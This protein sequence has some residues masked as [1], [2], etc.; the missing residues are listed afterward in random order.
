M[1]KVKFDAQVANL[2]AEDY[3]YIINSTED[4]IQKSSRNSLQTPYVPS[5]IRGYDVD[6]SSLDLTQVR[7]YHEDGYG[8]AINYYGT[9]IESTDETDQISLSDYTNG[10]VNYIYLKY[11]QTDASYNRQTG[12]IEDGVK[13]AVDLADFSHEYDRAVDTQ[14]FV[15]YTLSEYLATSTGEQR[16]LI[17]L[18]TVVAQGAGNPLTSVSTFGRV[19]GKTFITENTIS[20]QN[21]IGGFSLPQIQV[22]NS[23]IYNDYYTSTGTATLEDDLNRL[24]T[25]IRLMKGTLD[26]EDSVD[27]NL[28]SFDYGV[29]RLHFN[30]LLEYADNLS[31]VVTSSGTV[32]QINRGKALV[33]GRVLWVEYEPLYLDV[34]DA[35]RRNVGNFTERTGGELHAVGVQPA[36]FYLTHSRIGNLYVT[37]NANP[38]KVYVQDIDYT[39][40]SVTGLVTTIVGG[41]IVSE[42]LSC[43]YEWGYERYDSIEVTSTGQVLYRTGEANDY[44]SPPFYSKDYYR[45][46]TIYRPQL[47]ATITDDNILDNRTNVSYVREVREIPASQ[48][49]FQKW[50][51]NRFTYCSSDILESVEDVWTEWQPNINGSEYFTTT[52]NGAKVLTTIYTNE[53]DELW[54]RVK[55]GP[56]EGTVKVYIEEVPGTQIFNEEITI[57]PYNKLLES[58]EVLVPVKKG[59]TRGYHNVKIELISNDSFTI[60]SMLIGKLES[61]YYSTAANM[62]DLFA[63]NLYAVDLYAE[64]FTTSILVADAAVL[65]WKTSTGYRPYVIVEYEGDLYKCLDEHVSTSTGTL[66]DDA[67]HWEE[68]GTSKRKAENLESQITTLQSTI[69]DQRSLNLQ[70]EIRLNYL[71]HKQFVTSSIFSEMFINPDYTENVTASYQKIAELMDDIDWNNSYKQVDENPI[72]RDGMLRPRKIPYMLEIVDEYNLDGVGQTYKGAISRYDTTN[73]C[74][75]FITAKQTNDIGE[76]VKLSTQMEDGKVEVLGRWYLSAGGTSTWWVGIEVDVSNQYLH[77][78][79]NADGTAGGMA[80][81]KINDD[82]TLG[83]KHKSNGSTLGHSTTP[84]GT[85]TYDYTAWWTCDANYW[86][87]DVTVWNDDDLAVLACDDATDPSPTKLIMVGRGMTGGSYQANI[88]TDI[89]GFE[90]YLTGNYVYEYKL[91]RNGNE[92][93]CLINDQNANYRFIYKFEISTDIVSNVVIKASGRFE[94]S[95]N[96][97]TYGGIDGGITI[98]GITG[99]VLE[100]TSTASNG[101]FLSRRAIRN[102]VWAENQVNGEYKCNASTNPPYTSA[103]MVEYTG[104][105][106]YYWTGDDSVTANE[107]DIYRFKISDGTYKHARLTNQAW[108]TLCD[109]TYNPNTDVLY[110][111]GYD[112]TNVEVFFGD[113]SDF[114]ALMGNSYNVSNTITLGSAWGTL[115][116]GIGAAQ[117]DW[118]LGICYDSDDDLILITNDTDDKIDALSLDG[119]VYTQGVYDLPAATNLWYGIAYRNGYIYIMDYSYSTNPS[120]I[121]VLDKSRCTSTQWYRKHIHQNPERTF[122]SGGGRGI[123]FHVNDLVEIGYDKL[124][125]HKMKTL[126]DPAVMQLHTFADANNILLSNN[127]SCQTKI[128]TRYFD[129]SEYKEYLPYD[130]LTGRYDP[131]KTTYTWLASKRNVP[132]LHYMAVGYGNEGFSLLHLDEFLSEKSSSWMDRYDV[133][134]IRVQHYKIGVGAIGAGNLIH[135]GTSSAYNTSSIW[136]EKDML[137]VARDNHTT[138]GASGYWIDLKSGRCCRMIAGGGTYYTG[139]YY[140][141]TLTERNDGKGYSGS[142]NTELDLSGSN[143]YKIHGRTFEKTD[144]SDYNYENPKTFFSIGTNGGCDLLV[145]DWDENGNRTPLKVWNNVFN[146]TTFGQYAHFISNDGHLF[147]GNYASSGDIY[148]LNRYVWE[149]NQDTYTDAVVT[150]ASILGGYVMDISPNSRCWKTASGEWRHQLVCG[151][152]RVSS[153]GDD[154][155]RI[156]DVENATAETVHTYGAGAVTRGFHMV[157]NFEDEIFAVYYDSSNGYT[158]T[159]SFKKQ[160]F[161]SKLDPTARSNNW[162]MTTIGNNNSTFLYTAQENRP[163]FMSN[164]SVLLAWGPRNGSLSKD[165]GIF[166]ICNSTGGVQFFNIGYQLDECIHESIEFDCENPRQYYYMQTALLPESF[167]ID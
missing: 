60:Y 119:T 74:Y 147:I 26:W 51:A 70:Q 163:Y 88:T 36:S 45:L 31:A 85:T 33:D 141:G 125:F 105:E 100:V 20:Y 132:D 13:R 122:Y 154:C 99:D 29:N 144:I 135:P 81:I 129:P 112:T 34:P 3:E 159:Y 145:I 107:V 55:R 138:D 133:S 110:L 165:F 57:T 131:T 16:N 27:A 98:D 94:V 151:C 121:Y 77:C 114:V 58:T 59:F 62:G 103:C 4:E 25:E 90:K 102:A 1:N 5:V 82:G 39:L 48:Y 6:V 44:P 61:Y 40:N 123:D 52:T 75:W 152:A 63:E 84:D 35:D 166:G 17:C 146:V 9:L 116:S 150:G 22:Y 160:R 106:Y 130:V 78:V 93:W 139:Y 73:Q 24:R 15:V 49:A 127:V 7:V 56:D 109:A 14:E 118:K 156:V 153:G 143:L 101:K 8:C 66:Y 92:L 41:D 18:G 54:L 28:L 79:L 37:D 67:E 161:N 104:G 95:R 97:D 19:Y 134:K 167:Q 155:I 11:S 43:Y 50:V 71:E 12:L 140:N 32:I 68:I 86:P 46:Y 10:I 83:L 42:T 136:I 115:S 69:E 124:V 113:L 148:R 87:T 72:F 53:D 76:I 21:L 126:E 149:C 142:I 96:I 47:Q 158:L 91:I 137:F 80:G 89:T 157:D 65:M 23:D 2:H 128:E 164:S 108:V 162:Q 38:S 120:L 30:G 111:M 117:T 64:A